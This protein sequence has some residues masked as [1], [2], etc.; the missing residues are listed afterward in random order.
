MHWRLA[1]NTIDLGARALLMGV[2]NVTPDSFS[3]GGRFLDPGAAVSHGLAMLEAGADILDLGGESTR[4]GANEVSEKEELRRVLPVIS[5]LRREASRALLSIDTSKSAVAEAALEA[6]AAIVNDVTGLRGDPRMAEVVARGRAGLILMH[7]QGAPRDMQRNPRYHD[8]VREVRAF[9]E[10]RL[11][12]ASE[13]GIDPEAILFDPGIGFGKTLEHN[14]ALLQ[15]LDRLRAG[16]RPLALGVSR[17]SFLGKILGSEELEDRVWP[18]VALTSYARE[19]GV[20]LL[21]VHDVTQNLEALRMTEAIVNAPS[22]G[23]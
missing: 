16:G 10:E 4:P 21:R 6:G 15:A 18:T 5:L 11:Q 7:M 22:P 23:V 8:V 2:L 9:F 20:V 19:R 3:D 13:A 1:D 12:A 17:K 14:L